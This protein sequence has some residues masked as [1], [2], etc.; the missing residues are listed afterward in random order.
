M[1]RDGMCI[2]RGAFAV[3]AATAKASGPGQMLFANLILP[4][5]WNFWNK[6]PVLSNRPLPLLFCDRALTFAI[7]R[8]DRQSWPA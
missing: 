3:V 6:R 5:L 8:C 7:S 1:L 4:S 2:A